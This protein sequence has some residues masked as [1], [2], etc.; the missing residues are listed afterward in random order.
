MAGS[1]VLLALR[2][3][4]WTILFP[5]TVAIYVP[6]RFF[7]LSQLRPD[8]TNPFDLLALLM[9][10]A[11]IALELACVW[12]FAARGRGTLSPVDPPKELVVQGLYRYVRNP[13]YLSVSTILLGEA[14]LARS[15]PLLLYWAV[16]FAFVNMF[17]LLYE[18][19]ALRRQ[20]GE[21]YARY[22]REV[23]RW[24]PRRPGAGAIRDS[25]NTNPASR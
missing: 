21:S 16:F 1:S 23:G 18:E 19:P 3:L 14:L 5:G 6:W 4:L 8:F 7:G 12:E 22:T 11:G 9:I 20:F 13:M 25:G 24:L 10:A 2:S 17:V 15:I